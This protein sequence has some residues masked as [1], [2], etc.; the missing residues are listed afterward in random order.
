MGPVESRKEERV[1]WGLARRRSRWGL[2][3]WVLLR[4]VALL[5]RGR[6]T[7][8]EARGC[9]SGCRAAPSGFRR[10]GCVRLPI[11]ILSLS[12][13]IKIL[14]PRLLHLV[15]SSKEKNLMEH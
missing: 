7:G 3:F 14:G 10:F 4:K 5:R 6:Q 11:F 12:H 13:M 2:G 9:A 1:A 15:F 8:A